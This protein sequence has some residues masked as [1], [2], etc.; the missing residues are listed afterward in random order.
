MQKKNLSKD[1]QHKLKSYIEYLL[2]E[3]STQKQEQEVFLSY[4]PEH[5][6]MEVLID[7]NSK[8]LTQNFIF[9]INFAKTFLCNLS[10]KM[11]ERTL[12]PGEII[13]KV[14]YLGVDFSLRL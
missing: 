8:V 13:F 1:I 6:R 7:I 9:N 4:I 12:G 3:E 11:N 5:I 10:Y 2:E 14:I